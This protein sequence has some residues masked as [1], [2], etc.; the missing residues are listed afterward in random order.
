MAAEECLLDSEV[1]GFEVSFGVG[2]N[3]GFQGTRKLQK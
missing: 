2:H 3:E 1:V